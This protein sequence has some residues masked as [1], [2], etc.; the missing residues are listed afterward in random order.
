MTPTLIGY[1]PKRR[2]RRPEWLSASQVEEVASVSPCF[3]K[4]PDGW[5][6][7]WRHNDLWVYDSPELAWS[8]V[9]AQQRAEFELYAYRM[10]PLQIDDTTEESFDIPRLTVTPMNTAFAPLGYD[11]VCR[12]AGTSFECSPLSCNRMAEHIATNKYCLLQ[13]FETAL[14]TA[15]AL[16]GAQCEPGP[17]FIVEVWSDTPQ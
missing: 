6:E 8:V 11:I 16:E 12:T 14:N 15:K 9:P 17:Y 3:A 1:F 2:T 10:F 7:Q 5:I 13:D 4:P